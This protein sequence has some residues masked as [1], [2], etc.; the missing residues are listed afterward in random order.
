MLD[1]DLQIAV[2]D[3]V[4]DLKAWIWRVRAGAGCHESGRPGPRQPGPALAATE[5][6]KKI[7]YVF[8]TNKSD[9]VPDLRQRA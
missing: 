6:K 7:R 9:L 1:I 5:R 2:T 4:L 8:T 3:K